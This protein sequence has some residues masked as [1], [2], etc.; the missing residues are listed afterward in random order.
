MSDSEVFPIRIRP[1]SCPDAPLPAR[2][3]EI[4]FWSRGSRIPAPG[5]DFQ[6]RPPGGGAKSES[7]LHFALFALFGLPPTR[8]M[9][10]PGAPFVTQYCLRAGNRA[11]GLVVGRILI[12]KTSK[13]AADRPKEGRS[14][15]VE[16]LPKR[17]RPKS[18]PDARFLARKHCCVG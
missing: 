10:E 16:A 11:S 12:G 2:K 7:R 9:P 14:I 17:I 18:S 4:S 8:A 5:P 1:K 6:A 15:N 3:H 13:S